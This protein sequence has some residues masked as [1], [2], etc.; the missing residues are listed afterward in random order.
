MKKKDP[1]RKAAYGILVV[2]DIIMLSGLP[3]FVWH[4]ADAL[5]WYAAERFLYKIAAGSVFF[6]FGIIMM[7]SVV[8]RCL[9]L[10]Y[11]VAA[12]CLVMFII[13]MVRNI[14]Q[15]TW[16]SKKT[17]AFAVVLWIIC[18]FIGIPS[19]ESSFWAAM[20]V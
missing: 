9:Y 4:I 8:M 1:L 11:I 18:I 7:I 13:V 10:Q 20:S 12:I 5:K 19:T 2:L 14:M 3:W 6:P 17:I 15:K 16:P